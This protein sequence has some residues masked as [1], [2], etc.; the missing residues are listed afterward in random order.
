[1]TVELQSGYAIGEQYAEDPLVWVIDDFATEGEREHIMKIAGRSMDTARVSKLG[2]NAYSEKRT[3]SV[4]WLKHD[5]TPIVRG[6]VKRVS[7]LVDIPV[8]HA[9]SL[10]VVHY[11]ETQE[12]KPHYDA[13][14]IHSEKGREKTA[15]GGQR[16]LTALMY[17]NEV[18]AG[19]STGFPN[20]GI[21][22]E[23]VPGRMVLFHNLYPGEH[24]RHIDSLHGG[25]PVFYGEKWACNLWFREEPYQGASAGGGAPRVKVTRAARP[26]SKKNRKAQRSARKKNR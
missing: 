4:A 11:A 9:E 1:M 15:R 8:R 7:D 22:V 18:D 3:G 21:E 16:A 19:G 6:L 12:Y 20:L 10:Q 17:L 14:D 23:P 13:W 25:M 26:V 2:D 24:E 5:H